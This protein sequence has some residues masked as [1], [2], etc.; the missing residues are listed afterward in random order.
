MKLTRLY[1]L[2]GRNLGHSFSEGWFGEKFAR[3]GIADAEY[4]NFPL[5]DIAELPALLASHPDL[6]GFNVTI[7]YKESILPYLSAVEGAA[8]RIGAVNCVA[9]EHVADEMACRR[10]SGTTGVGVPTERRGDVATEAFVVEDTAEI[11]CGSA[12]AEMVA[13]GLRGG[14]AAVENAVDACNGLSCQAEDGA[15]RLV[16]Y[17]T[18]APAFGETLPALIGGERPDALV[19]G[20]GGAAK[21]VCCALAGMGIRHTVVSRTPTDG[22]LSYDRLDGGII[23][24]HRL[25]VNTTPLGMWPATDACPPIPYNLLTPAHFLY[26]LVYNPV[27]TEFLRLGRER[28]AATMNG[29]AML[30]RQAELSWHIWNRCNC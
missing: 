29:Q 24:S 30:V 1:G 11:W 18:D 4:R 9:V 25:I 8:E 3:E 16:G 10:D 15:I 7:P 26:D 13:A 2:I 28:G 27:E 22:M 14:V 17:N 21:A 12:M 5:A 20:S 23:A 19:L 6:R